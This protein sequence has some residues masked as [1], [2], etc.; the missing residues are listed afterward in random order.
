MLLTYFV[1]AG[2]VQQPLTA[3]KRPLFTMKR[4]DESARSPGRNPTV[5]A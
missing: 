1:L 5:T 4:A 2:A 3:E